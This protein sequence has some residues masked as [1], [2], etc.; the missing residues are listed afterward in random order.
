MIKNIAIA[1]LLRGILGEPFIKWELDLGL[2]KT[3]QMWDK[4]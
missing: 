2:E 3:E 4:C 1:S